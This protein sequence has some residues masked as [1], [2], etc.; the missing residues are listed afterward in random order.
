MNNKIWSGIALLILAAVMALYVEP[1]TTVVEAQLLQQAPITI[2]G[3]TA[4]VVRT[5]RIKRGDRLWLIAKHF[6]GDG[7]LWH[8]I[9]DANGIPDPNDIHPGQVIIIPE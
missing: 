1:Q 7:H 6:Y 3:P 4:I 8:K 2:P 5:Y 9:A